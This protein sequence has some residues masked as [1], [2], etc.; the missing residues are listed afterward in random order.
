MRT[1]A[2]ALAA[3]RSLLGD[4]CTTNATE[5]AQH[6][7]D[8]SFHQPAMPEAVVFPLTTEEV[9]AVVRLCAHHRIP[10]VPF[11]AG[12]SMEA[13]CTPVAGGISI[14]LSRMDRVLRISADDLDCTVQ[15]GVRRVQLNDQL[16]PHGI[17]FP[18]D[19]GADATIGGMASTGASG[20]TTVKYGAMRELVLALT[21]VTPTGDVITT[22]RRAR[23]TSAGYDLTHLFVGAEGT[24]GI[25]TELT[26]RVFGIPEVVAAATVQF[27]S[28]SAAV[29]AVIQTIQYGI[30][31]ARIELLDA[32]AVRAVN[33]YSGIELPERTLLLLEFHGT[34]VATAHAID[35][36][37]D[38]FQQHDGEGFEQTTDAAERRRLWRAR[39]DA[40]LACRATK[41]GGSIFATD[42]CVPISSL[43]AAV[44]ATRQDLQ[45]HDVFGAILGHVGD[46]N[47]HVVMSV[48]RSDERDVEAAEAVHDRLV[49]RALE[50][51]GTCT[52]E[53]GVGVGKREHLAIELGDGAMH[54]MA[55][56]KQALD[57]LGIMNPGKVIADRYL[58]G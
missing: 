44:E 48:D 20:T 26:L 16:A 18:V 53:H 29:N 42:V 4:R 32:T 56:V 50:L 11:G 43:A 2:D 31:V 57:P 45:D 46:G 39:H 35:Q 22:A 21:V 6:A 28:M 10:V 58:V 52:G 1:T 37:R 25:I 5:L 3:L 14:D 34:E 17:F 9:A 23:K 54:V 55:A 13:N 51:G 40:A 15:P 27:P 19:P 8:E 49:H 7:H 33:T 38:V 41:P 30:D 47:Y 24:L 12:T 36:C